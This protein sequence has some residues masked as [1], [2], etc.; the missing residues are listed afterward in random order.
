MK[1]HAFLLP[2]SENFSKAFDEI[3]LLI[4]RIFIERTLCLAFFKLLFDAW[5]VMNIRDEV[6]ELKNSSIFR[7]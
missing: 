7:L 5:G 1:S 6:F 3:C 2:G 4:H